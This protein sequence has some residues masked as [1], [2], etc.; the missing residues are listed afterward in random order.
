MTL[1]RLALLPDFAE[2]QWPSMDLAAEQLLLGLRSGHADRFDAQFARPPFFHF[3]TRLLGQRGPAKNV[4]R[5][6]NRFVTYPRFARKISHDFDLFHLC[7]HS[8]SQVIH[9][10]P[11]SRTGVFC[12]DLDTFRCLLDP[13]ADPRPRWFRAM[14]TRILRGMQ[15]AAIVFHAT[16]AVRSQI[17]KYGLIDPARLVHA[18]LG[19]AAEFFGRTAMESAPLKSTLLHVG[20][21]IPRK[22]ID[23]LINVLTAVKQQMPEIRLIQIGGEFTPAQRQQI[24]ECGV[25]NLITQSRGLTRSELAQMYRSASLVLIISE[26]EGFGLP[27]AEALASGA[28]VLASDIPVLREVGGNAAAYAP[29]AD[30][31]AWAQKVMDM[32]RTPDAAPDRA[33]RLKWGERYSWQSHAA[34]ITGAYAR[35]LET[36]NSET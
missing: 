34:I 24:A 8:Y 18:P 10:L 28:A 15:K 33:I 9:S 32:L 19:V 1:A 25:E 30:V 26:A 36:R 16:L 31:Q 17:E 4:N 13:A 12:H 23:V 5:L 14:A 2:E 20:S 22:R 27:V 11:A 6:L 3:T 21:C 7:D 29:V 35:L